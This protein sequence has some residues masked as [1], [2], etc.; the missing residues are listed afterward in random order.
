[1]KKELLVYCFT[2]VISTVFAQK[3]QLISSGNM[4]SCYVD[5]NK[6]IYTWGLN[7]TT[8]STG[9]LGTGGMSNFYTTPQAIT[10]PSGMKF[11][12]VN[13]GTGNHF[14]AIDILSMGSKHKRHY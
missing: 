6:N 5:V 12:Q 13:T 11:K 8:S 4:V 9:L 7:K 14:L 1:M 10:T 3:E 2:C